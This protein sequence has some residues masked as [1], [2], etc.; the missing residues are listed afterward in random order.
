M[1]SIRSIIFRTPPGTVTR[2]SI[3]SIND[4]TSDLRDMLVVIPNWRTGSNREKNL[5]IFFD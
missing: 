4:L 3:G 2:T 5:I 1:Q